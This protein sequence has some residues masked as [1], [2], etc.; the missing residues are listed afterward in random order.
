[1]PGRVQ[2]A[3]AHAVPG[4]VRDRR[5]RIEQNVVALVKGHR[6]H[7]QQRPPAGGA[8]GK[9]SGVDAGLGD[10][11]PFGGQL[12]ELQQPVPAPS[13]RRDDCSGGR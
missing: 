1:M 8:G 4:Q 3:R 10:V 13:A 2:A 7:T 11:Y 6:G 9:L 12:V 5:Q